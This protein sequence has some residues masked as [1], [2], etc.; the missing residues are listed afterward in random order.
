MPV[1]ESIP[2]LDADLDKWIEVAEKQLRTIKGGRG[3]DLEVIIREL[4]PEEKFRTLPP[5]LELIY[6]IRHATCLYFYFV[7]ILLNRTGQREEVAKAREQGAVT[8]LAIQEKTKFI[9]AYAFFVMASHVLAHCEKKMREKDSSKLAQ[10]NAEQIELVAGKGFSNDLSFAFSSYVDALQV[11]TQEGRLVQNV[12]DLL[13]V[14]RDF[15]RVIV[16]KASIVGKQSSAELVALVENTTFRY[17]NF[18]VTGFGAEDRKEVGVIAWSPVE[19]HEVIG[20]SD[21]TII[22][23]RLCDRVALY[24]PVLQKNPLGEFGG[25]VES[26][27][28]DGPPGTGKTT[29]Q[30]MM[31]TRLALRAEQI[32]IPYVFKSVTADQIKSEWYG[33]TAQLIAELLRGV[34]DPLV[35]SILFVDDIDLLLTGDRNGPGT[36]GGDMDILKALMDFFSGTGTNYIENY[37]A[38]AA[39]NK[40][41]ASDGALRQR[42]VYRAVINGPA[43]WEEYTDLVALEL[44]QFQKTG[45]LKIGEGKYKPLSRRTSGKLADIYG[46]EL[47][48]KYHG[49]STGTW[50]DIGRFCEE[51]HKKDPRFTGRPVRNAIQVAIMQAAD[52]EIPEEWFTKPS[53]FRSRPWEERIELVRELYQPL[54]PDLI[55]M[56]L[57]RQMEAE[58]RYEREETE[59]KIQERAKEIA[60]NAKAGEFVSQ[61]LAMPE[62]TK[63]RWPF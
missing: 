59:R 12:D 10:L 14:T 60:I 9:S 17:Q 56:A 25:I 22:L 7:D 46:A 5:E 29:R 49:K 39:T 26:T 28:L 35:L 18:S 38:L 32:G 57:E 55:L 19:P 42:F 40:P 13:S 24:D 44:R 21:V 58:A 20:D 11:T 50:E 52:F 15:W 30:R 6:V 16:K 45:L 54:T 61:A 43:T 53:E 3:N 37:L 62:K 4:T 48:E 36:S 8:T 63:S 41:T 47:R 1:R 2:I 23:R 27:L 34:Q 33:R 31:M 51:L